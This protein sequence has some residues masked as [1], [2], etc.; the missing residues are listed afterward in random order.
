M[1][2]DGLINYS[3][4]EM[5][6]R[7]IVETEDTRKYGVGAMT[8]ALE[9]ARRSAEGSRHRPERFRW[10]DRLHAAVRQQARRHVISN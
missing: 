8:D 2:P 5:K 10:E 3:I 4:S 7:G 6:A 1:N 9:G